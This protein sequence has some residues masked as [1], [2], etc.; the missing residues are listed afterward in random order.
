[1]QLD[2][3]MLMSLFAWEFPFSRPSSIAIH[4]N[5]DVLRGGGVVCV[6]RLRHAWANP[7]LDFHDSGF[8]GRSHLINLAGIAVGDLLE[9]ILRA[10]FIV[11]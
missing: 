2:A 8:L 1:M 6:F 9:L 3:A 11:F 10:T 4:D 5:G 7:T